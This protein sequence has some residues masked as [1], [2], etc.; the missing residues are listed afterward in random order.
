MRQRREFRSSLRDPVISQ[1]QVYEWG[2]NF[3]NITA[4]IRAACYLMAGKYEE[5]VAKYG[6][7]LRNLRKVEATAYLQEFNYLA[8]DE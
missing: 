8:F 1:D 2:N 6:Y 4:N 7:S 3:L 5:R